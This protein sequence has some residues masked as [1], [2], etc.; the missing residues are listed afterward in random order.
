MDTEFNIRLLQIELLLFQSQSP[1][2][3]AKHSKKL[4]YFVSH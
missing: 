2:S 3:N 4:L 1:E